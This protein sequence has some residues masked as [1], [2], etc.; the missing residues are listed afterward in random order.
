M[1]KRL[2]GRS[3]RNSRRFAIALI[4]GGLIGMG[5]I[6]W[7]HERYGAMRTAM[8]RVERQRR[9][10]HDLAGIRPPPTRASAEAIADDLTRMRQRV[11]LME[12]ALV[13]REPAARSAQSGNVPASRT[14]A[15]FDLAAF[16]ERAGAL[17]RAHHVAI[18]SEAAH[19][20]FAEYANEAPEV[21]QIT[22]VF[23]QRLVASCVVESLLA[24]MPRA[25]LAIKRERPPP[26]Q[27][28]ADRSF[29]ADYFSLDRRLS[30][31]RPGHL[32]TTAFSVAFTGDTATLR[33]FLNQLARGEQPILVRSVEVEPREL[34]EV[35]AAANPR[36]NAGWPQSTAS[37]VVLRENR[38]GADA[39][40]AE[41]TRPVVARTTAKF[42]VVVE[43]VELVGKPRLPPAG[44]VDELVLGSW[45]PPAA[46]SRGPDW[47]FDVFTS[48]EIFYHARSNAFTVHP[49]T[50]LRDEIPSEPFGVE[51]LSIR[52]EAFRL[53]LIG[54][55]GP[56]D[57][58]RGAFEN[59]LTGEV[60]LAG[61][62]RAAPRHDVEIRT[63]EVKRWPTSPDEGDGETS[64][65]VGASVVRD[66]L[67][68]HDITLAEGITGVSRTMIATLDVMGEPE[69][70]EVRAGDRLS[71]GETDYVIE[72]IKASPPEV[73]ITRTS[74]KLTEPEHH[75]L[76]AP[77][78]ETIAAKENP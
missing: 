70:R 2:A 37:S 77:A 23:R 3:G 29:A 6:W 71:I 63:I 19:F 64:R 65:W 11:E 47:I 31:A 43:H 75:I 25:L 56:A 68:G 26:G 38:G 28:R 52:P 10:Q 36:L 8:A 78:P 21:G 55:V 24:A 42:T 46:Q 69:V 50:G 15:Y 33:A 4:A 9:E 45:L 5:E 13:G 34:G 20:G 73:A 51:V 66:T 17:A 16:V 35:L 27:A 30:V 54:H 74:P 22:A 76:M 40:A 62:G 61:A 44:R 7:I 59:T 18:A 41:P 14:E 60:F 72:A 1:K 57:D 39:R 48:P 12:T 32:E 67:T 58:W 53:R 49:P